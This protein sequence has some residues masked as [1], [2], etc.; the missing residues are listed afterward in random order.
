MGCLVCTANGYRRHLAA[1]LKVAIA[2]GCQSVGGLG[3]GKEHGRAGDEMPSS[4][5]DGAR[6]SERRLSHDTPESSDFPVYCDHFRDCP[7]RATSILLRQHG[8]CLST[9]FQWRYPHGHD[10]RNRRQRDFQRRRGRGQLHRRQRRQ[11]PAERRPSRR[12]AHRAGPATTIWTGP[13][14]RTASGATTATI[15]SYG[16]GGD[17]TIDTDTGN[18]QVFAGAGDDWIYLEKGLVGEI[19]DV[20]GDQGDDVFAAGSAP[21]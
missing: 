16:G 9:L 19:K 10:Y 15:A 20:F 1:V 14:A 4:D 5:A 17:D 12:R 13:P 2:P 8:N 18:D 3:N 6:Q 21:T 7:S 11:R